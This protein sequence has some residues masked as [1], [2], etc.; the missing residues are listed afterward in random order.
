MEE[1]MDEEQPTELEQTE[2]LD[3]LEETETDPTDEQLVREMIAGLRDPLTVRA[4]IAWSNGWPVAT[5]VGSFIF[6]QWESES[7]WSLAGDFS[8]WELAPMTQGNG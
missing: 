7:P 8:G 2:D 1:A 4:H 6:V 5:E 3:R